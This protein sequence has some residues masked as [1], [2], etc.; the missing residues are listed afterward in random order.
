V[1]RVEPVGPDVDASIAALPP[2]LLAP[3]AELVAALE[4]SPSTVGDPLV[5]SNPG[6]LRIATIGPAGTGQVV[7]HIM[8]RERLVLIVQVAF[9]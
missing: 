9:V 6:G 2:E 1:Y 8:E 3:Y 7:F 4:L 5:P